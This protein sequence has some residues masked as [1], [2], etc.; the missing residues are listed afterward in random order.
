LKAYE[1]GLD[2]YQDLLKYFEFYHNERF[3]HSLD[4]KMPSEVYKIKQAA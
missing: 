3:H 1:N 2:L 4:Y